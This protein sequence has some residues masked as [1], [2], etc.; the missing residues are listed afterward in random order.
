M[1][2]E[3]VGLGAEEIAGDADDVAQVEQFVELVSRFADGVFANVDLQL[4]AILQ[5]T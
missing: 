5:Q 2:A 3:F 1:N 4:L